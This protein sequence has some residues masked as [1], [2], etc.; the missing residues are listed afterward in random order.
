MPYAPQVEEQADWIYDDGLLDEDPTCYELGYC[1]VRSTMRIRPYQL[2]GINKLV[3]FKR[4]GNRDRPGMGKTMQAA[5]AAA[6]SGNMSD[7]T[8]GKGVKVLIIAPSYLTGTWYDWLRGKDDK[9]LR[10][11][12]GVVIPNVPGRVRRVHGKRELREKA[13][14]S[15][16]WDW[17][18]VNQEM[19]DS[20]R[21]LFVEL[22]ATKGVPPK[23][24]TVIVDESHH[25]RNHIASRVK[26]LEVVGVRA[27]RIYLLSATMLWKEV[28]DLYMPFRLIAPDEFK[29]Y[30]NFLDLYC[31]ADETRFGPKVLGVKTEM[32]GHL[33]QLLA[34]MTVGR[35]YKEVGRSLPR[36]L[37]N[38]IKVDFPPEL[39]KAY[40]D[41]C[42]YWRSEYLDYHVENFSQFLNA[43]RQMT[44]FPGKVDSIREKIEEHAQMGH[45]QV[46]F[47][48]YSDHCEEAAVQLAD[49]GAVAIT[50][51]LYKDPE[52]RKKVALDPNNRIICANIAAL[53]EGI[54][55]SMARAVYFLEEHWP[56]GANDQALSRIQRE[57]I[58]ESNDEPIM[59]YYSHVKGTIDEVIHERAMQ[60]AGVQ[61]SLGLKE[62][63][64]SHLG[65]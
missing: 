25:F 29:S 11:N 15:N 6:I 36:V 16:K 28:D 64:F 24:A 4:Y 61:Q 2:E 22:Q 60:R 51:S 52:V 23:F 53:S 42:S 35:T 13:L 37:D 63:V 30:R 27:E 31:I 48:W 59:V 47:H 57:R 55:L 19:L 44:F 7:D 34:L 41:L 18:I 26:T 58:Y 65:I 14:R 43:T 39:Q 46:I 45:K 8:A 5:F 10:R 21:D 50:G 12:N 49:Y 62:M 56:P 1:N 3:R 32:T 33:K 38:Y 9:S 20:Y 17:Y 40:E 54:D